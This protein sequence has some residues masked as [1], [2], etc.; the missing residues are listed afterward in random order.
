MANKLTRKR[1]NVL[2]T[3]RNNYF[4]DGGQPQQGVFK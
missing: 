1:P 3:G 2:L 4:E